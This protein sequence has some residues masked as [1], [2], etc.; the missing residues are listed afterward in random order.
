MRVRGMA[1]AD[2]FGPDVADAGLWNVVAAQ[3]IRVIGMSSRR[4]SRAPEFRLSQRRVAGGPV[5]RL[6]NVVVEGRGT[7]PLAGRASRVFPTPPANNPSC[8]KS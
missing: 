3:G 8:P 7:D 4:T 6:L 5:R 1:C 2:P